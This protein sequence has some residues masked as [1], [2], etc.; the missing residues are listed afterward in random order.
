MRV[1]KVNSL[2][3]E[4]KEKE[5]YVLQLYITGMSLNSMHAVANIKAICKE[6]LDGCF[7]LEITD[8]YENAYAAEQE[9][10]IACPSLVKR[11]PL[12]KKTLIG[13]LSD[14]QKVL[15]ILG[16]E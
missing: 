7:E 14:T 9:Q 10:I 4:E 6:H 13:D 16:I 12:P 15:D 8:I 3:K 2:E 5:K 11:L 1:A